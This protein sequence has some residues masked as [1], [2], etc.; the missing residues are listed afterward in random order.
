MNKIEAKLRFSLNKVY[1]AAKKVEETSSILGRLEDS[2][3]YRRQAEVWGRKAK[4]FKEN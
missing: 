2:D 1:A 3:Y 4:N